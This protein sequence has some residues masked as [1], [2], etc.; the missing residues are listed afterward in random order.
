RPSLQPGGPPAP[1]GHPPESPGAGAAAPPP[2]RR[3][4]AFLPAPLRHS[5]RLIEKKRQDWLN[6]VGSPGRYKRGKMHDPS[7]ATGR[8]SLPALGVGLTGG[9]TVLQAISHSRWG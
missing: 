4:G 7:P 2:D 5:R 3:G 9:R 8:V 6:S 1:D